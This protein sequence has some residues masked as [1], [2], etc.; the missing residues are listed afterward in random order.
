MHTPVVFDEQACN[1]CNICVDLCP[2]DI[3]A[4]NP[5]KGKPPKVA[6]PNE[7]WYE[8][9]CWMRC[10]NRDQGAIRIVTPL[11]MRV[12]VLRGEHR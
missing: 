10:P 11:A 5:E 1:G 7:C 9:V 3:L 8:G 6:Y 2:M 4:P 12:S